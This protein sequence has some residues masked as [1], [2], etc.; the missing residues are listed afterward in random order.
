MTEPNT[1]RVLIADDHGMVREGLVVF[2]NAFDDL[3]LVDEAVNGVEA[4]QLCADAQP[5]VV[6][7]D[8][9]MPEMDGVSATR[10]ICQEYPN[11]RV[12]VLASFTDQDLIQDALRAG[13]VG[14]LLKNAT[15]DELAA[16]IRAAANTPARVS[17]VLPHLT[18]AVA[19]PLAPEP[20]DS[21]HAD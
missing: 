11:V 7:M 17:Q 6:L 21:N 18:D 5:D 14:Y 19:E 4:I 1:I 16:A 10:V 13:A 3:E 12:I 9:M 2:L 20:E 15:I 8:L